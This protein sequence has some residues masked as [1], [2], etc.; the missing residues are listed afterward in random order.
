[1]AVRWRDSL[2]LT[3][4][5]EPL[6]LSEGQQVLFPSSSSCL[7]LLSLNLHPPPPHHF[8]LSSSLHSKCSEEGGMMDNRC[9]LTY[10]VI[11]HTTAPILLTGPSPY[12]TVG[13]SATPMHQEE[14]V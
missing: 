7:V 14:M 4:L 8:F 10:C 13:F 2:G 11:Y 1:M 9:S 12:V 3:R 6:W 5:L